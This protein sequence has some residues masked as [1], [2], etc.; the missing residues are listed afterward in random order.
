MV[1]L[2]HYITMNSL[3]LPDM[4]VNLLC[5]CWHPEVAKGSS[6]LSF[7]HLFISLWVTSSLFLCSRLTDAPCPS[8]GARPPPLSQNGAFIHRVRTSSLSRVQDSIHDIRI[9][10]V[11]TWHF[12][13]LN[14][15]MI[16]PILWWLQDLF[17]KQVY[18]TFLFWAISGTFSFQV[19]NKCWK[20]SFLVEFG[21]VIKKLNLF[22]PELIHWKDV[23]S[24][25]NKF[26][27]KIFF[28]N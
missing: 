7:C 5:A 11:I 27:T 13:D 1:I 15:M 9:F 21:R 8:Y 19:T 23:K 18:Q 4:H 28:I 12:E 3:H 14:N 2:S 22:Y 20:G 26:W 16:M 6:S 17:V 25:S 10:V 24:W